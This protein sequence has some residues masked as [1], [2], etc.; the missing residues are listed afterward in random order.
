MQLDVGDVEVGPR[1]QEAA[2][3][4]EIRG[5]RPAP[6]APVLADG[7]QQPRHRL[8]REAVEVRIV[9]QVAKDEIRMVLQIMPDAGQMMHAGNAV[10]AEC[11]TVADAGQHQ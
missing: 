8:H 6:F 1:F 5:H 11:G 4:G 10:L 7:A 2:A 3:F 9:R